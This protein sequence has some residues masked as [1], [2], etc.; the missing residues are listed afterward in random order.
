SPRPRSFLE[1]TVRGNAPSSE[2]AVVPVGSPGPGARNG[3]P[4]EPD[5]RPA[6]GKP[7]HK[8]IPPFLGVRSELMPSRRFSPPVVLGLI[9]IYRAAAGAAPP[10]D[11]RYKLVLQVPPAASVSSVTVSPDGSLVAT[12]GEGGVR[13]HDAKSGALVRALG[14]AGDRSVTF[15]P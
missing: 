10:P 2:P 7:R 6:H 4:T 13:L 15:S 5:R 3:R 14:G 9:V 11:P 8:P 1:K 12:A